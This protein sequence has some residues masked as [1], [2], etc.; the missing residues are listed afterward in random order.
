MSLCEKPSFSPRHPKLN[1]YGLV[2]FPV[3]EIDVTKYSALQNWIEICKY[4]IYVKKYRFCP[5]VTLQKLT[6]SGG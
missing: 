3:H 1:G 6:E 2:Y 4:Q 5:A